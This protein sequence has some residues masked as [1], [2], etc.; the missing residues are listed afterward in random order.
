ELGRALAHRLGL[1]WRPDLITRMREGERQT[2][3]SRR[4]RRHGVE[5]LYRCTVPVAGRRV[6]LVDDV[7]T[8]GSTLD[9]IA[10]EL[11]QR[12]AGPVG[13]CL[14][15]DS[16]LGLR[17]GAGGIW[18]V[19]WPGLQDG[20]GGGHCG[21]HIVLARAAIGFDVGVWLRIPQR[22]AYGLGRAQPDSRPRH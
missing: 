9:A 15:V 1:A 17:A 8:T 19:A 5:G 3:R 14:M 13:S 4:L 12:G 10:R 22:Y 2:G 6:L 18:C 7:M 20:P 16:R 11:H 21:V